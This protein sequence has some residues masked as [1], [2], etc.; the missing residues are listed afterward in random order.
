[1]TLETFQKLYDRFTVVVC[2]SAAL[3]LLAEIAGQL[4]EL[5]CQVRTT[6]QAIAT[7]L[8]AATPSPVAPSA[9]VTSAEPSSGTSGSPAAGESVS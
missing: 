7:V 3:F 8:I 1:M 4:V 9:P 2:V 6:R 5:N